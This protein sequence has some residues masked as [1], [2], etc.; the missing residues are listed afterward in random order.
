VISGYEKGVLER[1][2]LREEVVMDTTM[3]GLCL[4]LH[5]AAL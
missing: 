3:G 1:D 4:H 5:I 2:I